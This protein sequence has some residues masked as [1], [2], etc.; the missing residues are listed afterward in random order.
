M[1]GDGMK[2]LQAVLNWLA[3]VRADLYLVTCLMAIIWAASEVIIG[4]PKQPKRALSTGGAWLLMMANA[5]F[6]CLALG[7]ALALVP[8]SASIWMALGVGLSW[9]SMLRGGINI[10]P[11]PAS[12]VAEASE[13][14]M[15][16][17]LNEL[18]TRLQS[19]CVGQIQRSLVGDRV[20]LMESII[21]TLDIAELARIS[22]LVTTA[23]ADSPAEAHQYIQRIQS[24]QK[25]SPEEKEILLISLILDNR[26]ADILRKRVKQAS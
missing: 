17:P 21:D 22:R 5:L 3:T 16:V 24:D 18:Y 6:A 9:Q 12:S 20:A 2:I 8:G 7:M 1:Q 10:Q 25:R 26:G 15:G 13:E 4:N 14:G 11:V 19:F 23:S